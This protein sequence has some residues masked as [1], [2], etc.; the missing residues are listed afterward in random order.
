MAAN[1]IPNQTGFPKTYGMVM[2]VI[3][4]FAIA[5]LLLT[6]PTTAIAH[7]SP[8]SG[9]MTLK[10]SVQTAMPYGE[11][12]ANP[13]PTLIEFYADWCTT[14]QA[15]APTLDTIHQQFGPA[16]NFV[17]IDIDA[18]QWREQIQQFQVQGV[19]HLALVNPDQTVADTF[20]GKVP[21]SVLANRIT[22]LMISGA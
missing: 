12:M 7:L 3:V 11:A 17:M 14:C 18:P 22:D 16:L 4:V 21:Q 20:I 8:L 2:A 1:P 19:P 10:A 13:Q 5:A 15:L 6:R 9:L